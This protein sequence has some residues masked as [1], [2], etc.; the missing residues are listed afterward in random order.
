MKHL[1]LATVFA[2]ISGLVV[3]W[4]AGWALDVETGYRYF[5]AYWG[6]FFACA[7]I[8]DGITHETT[9]AVAAAREDGTHGNAN[10]WRMGAVIGGVALALVAVFGLFGMGTICLLYTSPSPRD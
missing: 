7:G 2:A 3:V 1:S 4:V 6:L 9:R 10:P 5:L 8:V